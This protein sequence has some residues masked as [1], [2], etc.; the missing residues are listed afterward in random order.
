[1]SADVRVGDRA[2]AQIPLGVL[3]RIKAVRTGHYLHASRSTAVTA[4]PHFFSV[5]SIETDRDGSYMAREYWTSR[6]LQVGTTGQKKRL[7]LTP[8][9]RPRRRYIHWHVNHPPAPRVSP[10]SPPPPATATPL[11]RFHFQKRSGGH[12]TISSEIRGTVSF[13]R[14]S[15]QGPWFVAG[16]SFNPKDS[17]ALFELE[18]VAAA[19]TE[20]YMRADV[21]AGHARLSKAIEAVATRIRGVRVVVATA[22][23]APGRLDVAAIFWGWLAASRVRGGLLLSRDNV[24]CEALHTIN[25]NLA[26][27]AQCITPG[28]LALPPDV[29]APSWRREDVPHFETDAN[30]AS[31]IFLRRCKLRM[32]SAVL[33]RGHSLA[34]VDVDVFIVSR[35][36]LHSLVL[37]AGDLAIGR[38]PQSGFDDNNPGRC[39]RIAPM[40]EGL[41]SDWVSASQ[42]FVRPTEAGRWIIRSAE[43]LMDGHVLNDADALQALLTGHAQVSDPLRAPRH[44]ALNNSVAWLKPFWLEADREPF[45]TTGG[46]A[47]ARSRWIRPVNAPLITATWHRI[48]QEQRWNNFTWSL[49]SE[50]RF[51]FLAQPERWEALVEKAIQ[52]ASSSA[53]L[54]ASGSV[55]HALSVQISCHMVAWLEDRPTLAS[56]LLRPS[57]KDKRE[58]L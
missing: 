26:T 46:S 16:G 50:S 51:L 6:L 17:S 37:T 7:G 39:L 12:V 8:L 19:G 58:A 40:S 33:Q 14:E 9:P 31:A 28:D 45:T 25:A 4:S 29:L 48:L 13:L 47:L 32:V 15:T 11:Q 44:G 43:S 24:A 54:D 57:S 21:Q 5:F 22:Y 2:T 3:W 20:E 30:T 23:D 34:F 53:P 18:R 55:R 1:M 56:K 38:D 41:V 52:G 35:R 27:L 49:L 42:F 10:P 36:Y